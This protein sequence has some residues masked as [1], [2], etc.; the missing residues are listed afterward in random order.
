MAADLARAFWDARF[1]GD[2][3]TVEEADQPANAAAAYAIQ[4]DSVALSGFEQV[5]W[6]LGATNV[7][8]LEMLGLAE[9]I[10][11]PLFAPHCYASGARVALLTA[12]RIAVCT[13]DASR[14]ACPA[15]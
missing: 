14:A 10:L 4:A 2:V 5:G 8:I 12:G 11:G 15:P 3:I 9:P 1:S 7:T 13:S 6:K